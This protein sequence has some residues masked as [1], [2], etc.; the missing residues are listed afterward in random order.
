MRCGSGDSSP[1][2]R[3]GSTRDRSGALTS[4]CNAICGPGRSSGRS[5][6]KTPAIINGVTRARRPTRYILG[7]RRG[8]EFIDLESG[9]CLWNSWAHGVCRYG[10]MPANGLLYVPPHSC[11]CYITAKLTGFN[12]M[13]AE[14]SRPSAAAE[15]VLPA[16]EKGPAYERAG[17][18]PRPTIGRPTEAIRG[19][20]ASPRA[21]CHGTRKPIGRSRL[22]G[23]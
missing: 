23:A 20:A 7:G 17:E 14:R 5:R 1:L 18:P 9:E 19:G 2:T 4:P 21:A 3:A 16:V 10:V 15:V 8:T 11:G 6:P 13:A 22:C 12:A